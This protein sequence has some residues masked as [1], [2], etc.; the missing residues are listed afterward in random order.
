MLNGIWLGLML[1]SVV[2]AAFTGHMDAVT[3]AVMGCDASVERLAI[4]DA[5]FWEVALQVR[6]GEIDPAT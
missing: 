4:D 6:V 2:Y 5:G 1:T 3:V